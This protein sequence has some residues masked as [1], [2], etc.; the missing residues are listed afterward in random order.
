[1]LGIDEEKQR[2]TR[3][4]ES[5]DDVLGVVE[6]DLVEVLDGEL[7]GSGGRRSLDLA[8]DSGLLSDA[9]ETRQCERV[10]SIMLGKS[11]TESRRVG[12]ASFGK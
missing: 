1:M 8:L 11:Q 2:L 10:V 9:A 12:A 6:G 5:D 7:E 3:S 4:G